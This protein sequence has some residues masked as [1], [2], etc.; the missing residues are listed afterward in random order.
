MRL[1]RKKR[2]IPGMLCLSIWLIAC[3]GGE[4]RIETIA[5][6][7]EAGTLDGPA[8]E[9]KL[10]NPFG[11]VRGPDK[12]LWFCEYDGHTIRKMDEQGIISTVVGKGEAGYDGD[13]GPA[14]EASLNRPHEIRF[15]RKGDLFIADM[16]NH[17]IRK[18]DLMTGLISTVVG[19]GEAGF[20]GDGGPA[21][22]A[23]L[24]QPH[25][26]QFGP[27][28]NL[29][30]ADVGNHRVRLVDRETKQI[31]TLAGTGEKGPTPDGEAFQKVPLFGPRSLDFDQAG[32]L[33]LLLK[34]AHQLWRLDMKA[35]TIHHIAGTGKQGFDGNGGPA[36]EASLSGPKGIA[37]AP[38]GDVFIADT[39]SH[40][41]RMIE[42]STGLIEAVVGTGEQF[43]GKDGP[44]SHCGLGRPHGVFV[45]QDGTILIGDSENHKIRRLHL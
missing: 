4:P 30:I 7:G 36:S 27:D 40:S 29:Y 38:N 25:S 20:S 32:D 42:I 2:M 45:D 9:A 33:W 13:G 44:A 41:I 5:G 11:V 1:T 35:G 34:R 14:I 43:D 24:R 16:S 37:I 3:G 18:V 19:T 26:I 17:V 8:L 31:S 10:N 22:A 39:E 28:G 6:T 15:D 21:T 12:A 23:Q